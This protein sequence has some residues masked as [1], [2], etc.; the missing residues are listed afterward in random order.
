MLIFSLIMTSLLSLTMIGFGLLFVRKAPK[1]INYIFGYRSA[2]SMKNQETWIFAHKYAGKVWIISG[3]F[4]AIISVIVAIM[5]KDFK[6]YNTL[7]TILV[8]LQIVVLL[9][10]IPLTEIAL[11]KNFDKEGNRKKMLF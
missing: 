3:V 9:L 1:N 10:V 6:N 5:L 2:L 8:Y 7:M 4:T 11:R